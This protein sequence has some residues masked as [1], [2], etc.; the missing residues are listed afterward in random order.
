MSES[1]NNTILKLI[2]QPLVEN[3]LYHGIKNKRGGRH[4][5]RA[6]QTEE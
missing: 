1:S 3:A 5:H 4:D 6:R 2:L